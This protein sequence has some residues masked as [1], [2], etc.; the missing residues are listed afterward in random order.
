MCLDG[1]FVKTILDVNVSY[2][3]VLF[4]D[5]FAATSPKL[6][7]AAGV[8]HPLFHAYNGGEYVERNWRVDGYSPCVDGKPVFVEFQGCQWHGC[9]V[10]GKPPFDDDD[11][12]A[13]IQ[14]IKSE[15][16]KFRHL[17]SL[18][19]LVVARECEWM[20]QRKQAETSMP[21]MWNRFSTHQQLLDGIQNDQLY[22]FART[23][24]KSPRSLTEAS[25]LRGFFYPPLA[26]KISLKKEFYD[27]DFDTDHLPK[28][29]QLVCILY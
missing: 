9:S 16:E 19:T 28:E 25:R 8:R 13:Q 20:A 26:A 6:V 4:L 18:G 27:D 23:Q 21:L 15:T 5:H 1:K 24:V 17:R 11:E 7:D 22:G 10:C 14:R 2:E 3:A 12:E 29:K